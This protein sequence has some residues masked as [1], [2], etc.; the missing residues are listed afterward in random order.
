MGFY[1]LDTLKEDARR[2]GV[3]VLNPD[4][5]ASVEKCIVASSGLNCMNEPTDH[6]SPSFE[7]ALRIGLLNVSGIGKAAARTIVEARQRDGRYT[8]LGDT[9]RRTGLQRRSIENLVLAGALDSLTSDRRSALWEVGLRHRPTSVAL[10][11]SNGANTYTNLPRQQSLELPVDQDMASLR[12][13][14]NWEKMAGEYQIMGLYPKGHLMEHIRPYLSR[15]ILPS[16]ELPHIEE[17]MDV[18]VAGLVIRRQQPLGKTVFITLEDEFG[19][20]PLLVWPKVYARY[21]LVLR[22][23]VLKVRGK[24]TRRERTLNIAITYAES[25][26]TLCT[27]PRTKDWV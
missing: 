7:E 22:E 8:S 10:S 17:G 11:A 18:W 27:T 23:P 9:M 26:R 25:L 3:P 21:R 14:T 5:N 13:M 19:H 24:V 16:D 6:N 4:I 2:H 12:P 20:I 1:N 15:D